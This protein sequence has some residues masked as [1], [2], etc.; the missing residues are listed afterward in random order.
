MPTAGSSTVGGIDP[1]RHQAVSRAAWIAVGLLWFVALLNYLDR[2]VITTMRESVVA[3]VPMTEA[4][5]GLL[6]SVFLWIYGILSPTCGFLADRLSRRRVIFF[7]LL[8]WSAVTWLTGHAQ[9]FNQL[10]WAR[11]A[12]GISEACYLPAALALIADHHRGRTRSFATALH[13]TGIYAG[14]A[15]GGI[16]GY[17]AETIGWRGGFTLLGA[18]GISY[19]L[20]LLVFLR[21]GED[22][23]M[24]RAARPVRPG[25]ALH[26]LFSVPA[27]SALLLVN[28]LVGAANWTIYGWLPT[29]FREQFRLSQSEAGFAATGVLQL[30]SFGGIIVGGL[31]ADAWSRK[32]PRARILMPGLAYLASAPALLLLAS[33]ASL[34]IALAGLTVY[35]IARGFF[36]ANLMPI[37][38]QTV[39][40]RFS[41]TAYGFLNFIGCMTGG[42][43]AYFGGALRDAKI[44]LS[45]AF[46]I[47]AAAIL[48]S[49]FLLLLLKPRAP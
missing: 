29:F 44:S 42:V 27:F 24:E 9:T 37:V 49:G 7:S 15:L 13:G 6:T 10:F 19:A 26:A 40:E 18:V 21:N 41:A 11:A 14:G 28:S 45:L 25:E 35:G 1:P 34:G 43:M 48:V 30:S 4:Q 32:T 33:S 46:D 31:I 38:R 12:M 17:L 39:D 20:V 2:L 22:A 16:G 36:D 5:F 8:I 47:C 23:P 3:S